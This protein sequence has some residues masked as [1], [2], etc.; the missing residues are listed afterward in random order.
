MYSSIGRTRRTIRNCFIIG[1][2]L[3]FV[4][5]LSCLASAQSLLD[6]AMCR[7]LP[8]VDRANEFLTTDSHVYSWIKVG[9]IT[10]QSSLT[11][12][13]FSPDG[14]KYREDGPVL[15]GSDGTTY[16]VVVVAQ[17]LAI[18]AGS[19]VVPILGQWRVDVYM[20]GSLL[21]TERFSIVTTTKIADYGDAPDNQ[22]CGYAEDPEQDVLGRFPTLFGTE[23]SRIPGTPGAHALL[24]GEEALG[25]LLLTSREKD[26]NDPNDPDL[27]PNLVDDD[28]DDGLSL[29]L[30]SS[31]LLRAKIL[32]RVSRT[33]PH[34]VRYVNALYD[35][36][37]DGQ[38]RAS[39]QG[40]EWIIKNLQI[41]LLPG[42]ETYI[43]VPI[44][45]EQDWLGTL[46]RPRWLRLV[47]SREPISEVQYS[48]VGGWDGSGE[49][50]AGEIEDYKIGVAKA[51]DIAWAARSVY[52]RAWA[53]TW[54]H[55]TALAWSL[56]GAQVQ[57]TAAAIAYS[58]AVAAAQA[59]DAV[60]AEANAKAAS[61]A[62]SYAAAQVHADQYRNAFL[63]L[64]CV[65]IRAYARA[66]VDASLEAIAE[67]AAYARSAAEA[68]A[69]ASAQALAWAQSAATALAQARATAVAFAFA[70]AEADS[71]AEALAASWASS[72]A[73]ASAL[74]QIISTGQSAQGSALALAWVQVNAWAYAQASAEASANA[75]TL[76]MTYVDAIAGAYVHA[77]TAALAAAEAKASA[78]AWADAVADAFAIADV[79]LKAVVNAAAAINAEVIKDCCLEEYCEDCPTVICPPCDSCCPD[80]DPCT[81]ITAWI[82][83][84][85]SSYA[86]GDAMKITYQISGHAKISY[87][88]YRSDGSSSITNFGTRNPGTYSISGTAGT[89]GGLQVLMLQAVPTSGC[90]AYA[91]AV[92]RVA[93]EEEPQIKIQWNFGP[94]GPPQQEEPSCPD[95]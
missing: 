43:E 11:W 42:E 31:G 77:Q 88:H 1:G 33:A 35:I 44:L 23:N 37:R 64:P 47:L 67:A 73:W 58:E 61:V 22:P 80:C 39:A 95:D 41:T 20:D 45:M 27:T 75:W 57:V 92:F 8:A 70:V 25:S 72:R 29:K 28:I 84:D 76:A 21:V 5:A 4:V 46:L 7:A 49:F 14:R 3:L 86:V 85:K 26:A 56:A 78:E 65:R 15:V 71:R 62:A 30:V 10:G 54:A 74:A 12:K 51:F 24:V 81:C 59:A 36:N 55:A 48:M 2:A 52:R 6:H 69:E 82:K 79:S 94:F 50:G 60:W 38:W 13:W 40:D 34:G 87:V 93:E 9:P 63:A 83:T 91:I 89:P 32:V 53:S 18:L 68:A 19:G 66:S 17:E 16:S 90:T